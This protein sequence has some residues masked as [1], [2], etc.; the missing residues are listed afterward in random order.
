MYMLLDYFTNKKLRTIEHEQELNQLTKINNKH[1]I[2]TQNH[3]V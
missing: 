1:D 3:R 2:Y